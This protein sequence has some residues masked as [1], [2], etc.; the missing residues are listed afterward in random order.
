MTY[1]N[2]WSRDLSAGFRN[3]DIAEKLGV[4]ERTVKSR[5][6]SALKKLGVDSVPDLAHAFALLDSDA[7]P[8][9]ASVE[10]GAN[11]QV[12]DRALNASDRSANN[13][14]DRS[15]SN[16]GDVSSRRAGSRSSAGYTVC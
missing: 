14:G 13:A 1:Q 6:K 3:T 11:A 5:R 7:P 15:A 10:T 8:G 9:G 12:G 16:A 2:R 4:A